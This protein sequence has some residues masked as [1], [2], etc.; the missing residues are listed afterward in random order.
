MAPE[1]LQ[2]FKSILSQTKRKKKVER[3]LCNGTQTITTAYVRYLL[4][5][6]NSENEKP[7]SSVIK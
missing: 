6:Q 5:R 4:F 3:S 2:Q 1:L 7:K